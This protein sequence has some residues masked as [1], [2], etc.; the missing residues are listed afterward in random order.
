MRHGGG[1]FSIPAPT[2][3]PLSKAHPFR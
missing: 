2:A 3:D 1:A